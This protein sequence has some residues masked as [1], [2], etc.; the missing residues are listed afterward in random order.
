MGPML[1]RCLRNHLEVYANIGPITT[2]CQCVK[3]LNFGTQVNSLINEGP[4]VF[5]GLNNAIKALNTE[6]N[7]EFTLDGPKGR[8]LHM[9]VGNNILF[10]GA[11]MLY[12]GSMDQS[13]KVWDMDT[14][15]CTMTLNEHNDVVTSLICWD[16]FLLSSSFDGT[17]KI[18]ACMEVGTLNVGIVSLFGMPDEKGKHILFSSCRDNSVR[19]YELPSFSERGL[20]YAKKDISP[21]ELG[22]DELFFTGDG[23]GLVSIW[24]WNELPKMTSN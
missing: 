20:L 7:L 13:I 2:V 4:W 5:V 16:E 23:T 6:T 15:Q 14:L 10:V 18:W 22:P 9:T 1:L 17:I 24:K 8:I 3:A 21:F 12:S 11:E 19:M